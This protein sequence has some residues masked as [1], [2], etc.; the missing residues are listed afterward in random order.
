MGPV[1]PDA[2]ADR[3]GQR[4]VHV[5]TYLLSCSGAAEQLSGISGRIEQQ[6]CLLS[7]FTIWLFIV[8]Q[9]KLSYYARLLVNGRVVGT[10]EVVCLKEDFTLEFRDVFRWVCLPAP[11]QMRVAAVAAEWWYQALYGHRFADLFFFF[12]LCTRRMSSLMRRN[13]HCQAC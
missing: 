13:C 4:Q 11:A 1:K 5:V 12:I 3:P 6:C 10:S 7:A 9:I 2:V 8:M